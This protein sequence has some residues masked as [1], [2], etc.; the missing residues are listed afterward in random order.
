[1]LIVCFHNCIDYCFHD[2]SAN[3]RGLF[4]NSLLSLNQSVKLAQI[5]GGFCFEMVIDIVIQSGESN[6]PSKIKSV[7]AATD[8]A[9]RGGCDS[10]KIDVCLG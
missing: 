7:D 1:M 10:H 2:S 5:C 3:R 9:L 8:L 6:F 4:Y